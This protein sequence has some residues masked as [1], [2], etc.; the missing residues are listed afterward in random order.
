M[1][2]ADTSAWTHRH[3]DSAVAADFDARVVAGEIATCP[4]VVMELLWTA[5]SHADFEELRE[6]LHALENLPI[7]AATWTRA[8]DV[9]NELVIRGQHRV[10]KIPD[11]LVAAAAEVRGVA[12]CHYD[13]DFAAI[14]EVTG[15]PMRPIA[16]L[17]TL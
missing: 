3:K 14:S 8:I 5:R 13:A 2:L 16:P 1:E 4:Q 12:V 6:D 11:L 9:W 15:Q 17:G 7:E 10:A